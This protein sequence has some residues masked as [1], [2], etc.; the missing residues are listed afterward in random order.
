[1]SDTEVFAKFCRYDAKSG[2][3]DER[4]TAA[5]FLAAARTFVQENENIKPLILHELQEYKRLGQGT[6]INFVL[7][8]MKSKVDAEGISRVEQAIKELEAQ[9]KIVRN[10][11]ESGS[12][13][14]R[15][16]GYTLPTTN[17][18]AAV[19]HAV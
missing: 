15:T 1:M 16:A 10:V 13:K 11:S 9:S 8:S 4:A 6:L 7:H 18:T 12:L 2:K 3:L 14:G 19:S 17:G 5:E